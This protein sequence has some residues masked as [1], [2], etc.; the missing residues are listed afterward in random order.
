MLISHFVEGVR[1]DLASLGRLGNDEFEESARRLGEAAAPA[2]R[3]RLLEAL[4]LIVAEA[5]V[6]GDR[7]DLGLTLAGDEISLSRA[8]TNPEPSDVP[9]EFTARFALRLPEE[10]KAHVEQL[11]QEAGT[12][13]NAWIVRALAREAATS[14]KRQAWRAGRQLRG[15]GRS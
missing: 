10:V 7:H 9:G 11:A 12:S 3:T 8:P 6:D 15:T 13:T 1:A 14:T 2:L 5:N 4:D